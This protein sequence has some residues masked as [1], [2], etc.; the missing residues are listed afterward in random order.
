MTT[1]A[2]GTGVRTGLAVAAAALVAAG[3]GSKQPSDELVSARTAY[4]QAEKSAARDLVP[5]HLLTAK[6]ALDRAELAHRDSAGSHE[7]RTLAYVAERQA[8][9]A[10]AEAEIRAA[11][12]E[13]DEA[14]RVYREELESVQRK[15]RTTLA[16]TKDSL[17]KTKDELTRVRDELNKQ[18]DAL[19]EK[20]KALQQREKELAAKQRELEEERKRR[21]EAEKRA[22]A[23]LASLEE[24]AKIREEQR[25]LVITLSGGVLFRTNQS[26]LL[27]IAKDQLRRV[28]EALLEQ[29]D[30]K[31]IMV[32]GHTDS[33]GSARA[34]RVLSQA[35]ADS[36][37]TFLISSG[38]PPARIVAIGKGATEPIADN[39]SPEGRANN[40]R[41]EIIVQ[42]R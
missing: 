35:R 3:C 11:Q 32:E 4:G 13:L 12:A 39:R 38:V 40:R 26:D 6:Q 5:D 42:N 16:D 9:Q 23:A 24:I 41:V 33:R 15:T 22:A 17:G 30:S 31:T 7:E 2:I 21:E 37:R 14:Q 20:A 34:N 25:G 18:E 27:P 29:D 36:V 19:S 8:R 1:R 28:A 10:V